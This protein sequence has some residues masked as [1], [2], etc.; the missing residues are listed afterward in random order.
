MTVIELPLMEQAGLK[1][2][3]LRE[4]GEK[5]SLQMRDGADGRDDEESIVTTLKELSHST[6]VNLNSP[7]CTKGRDMVITPVTLI[8][9]IR[10]MA[11]AAT[12]QMT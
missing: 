8:L 1:P 2:R 12:K 5:I 11:E 4:D 9:M 10:P 3:R 7:N 6:D